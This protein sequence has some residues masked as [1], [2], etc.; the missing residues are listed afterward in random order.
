MSRKSRKNEA[1]DLPS[2]Q[3]IRAASNGDIEAINAV[4][5]HYEGYIAAL[6]MRTGYDA[7]G[8]PR[9]QVDEDLR[10]RLETK[11]IVAILRF[12]LN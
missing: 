4:L 6:S 2:F 5:K 10:Q 7:Q 8:I 11:L 9:T 1:F 3:M 12:E